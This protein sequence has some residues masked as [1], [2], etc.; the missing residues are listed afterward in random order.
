[1]GQRSWVLEY[2]LYCRFRIDWRGSPSHELST[3][4][5]LSRSDQRT[6]SRFP[7]A[8]N[9]KA[10]PRNNAPIITTEPSADMETENPNFSPKI[11]LGS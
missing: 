1:M 5:R 11:G 9:T 10:F 2:W 6:R 3:V 8:S 7:E 4:P